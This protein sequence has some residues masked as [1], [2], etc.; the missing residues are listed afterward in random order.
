MIIII[1]ARIIITNSVGRAA[2][3]TREET[4]E[5]S[6]NQL[7]SI[8]AEHGDPAPTFLCGSDSSPLPN[9][10][11]SV[12]GGGDFPRGVFESR[13]LPDQVLRWTRPLEYTDT[14]RYECTAE[15][16]TGPSTTVLDLLVRRK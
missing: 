13:L 2:T 14:G 10:T 6:I 9:L 3:I 12:M 16:T 11:W 8:I 1:I 7:L 4:A 15:S 5:T